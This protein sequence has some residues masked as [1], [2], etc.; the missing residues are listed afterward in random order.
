[1]RGAAA[2]YFRRGQ[3]FIASYSQTTDGFWIETEPYFFGDAVGSAG[4]AALVLEALEAT[5]L[6]IPTPPRD[7]LGSK[8]PELAGVKT[9]GTFMRGAVSVDISRDD[10]GT[11]TVTPMRNSGARAGFEYIGDKAV[12]VE[13]A[14]QL[15]EA[16][17]GALAV[18]E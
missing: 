4:V 9:Y 14:D 7:S 6:D 15:A 13:S 12:V 3:F 8:M 18:A 17:D 5:R 11:L 2:V 16:I 10:D 1:M